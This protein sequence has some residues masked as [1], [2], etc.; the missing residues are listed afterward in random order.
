MIIVKLESAAVWVGKGSTLFLTVYN[1]GPEDLY[2]TDEEYEP[3]A[4]GPYIIISSLRLTPGVG[5]GEEALAYEYRDIE[6][7]VAEQENLL[8]EADERNRFQPWVCVSGEDYVS[9]RASEGAARL[10]KGKRLRIQ[11][12]MD[13][14]NIAEGMGLLSYSFRNW[15]KYDADKKKLSEQKAIEQQ[16]WITKASM[17]SIWFRPEKESYPYGRNTDVGWKISGAGA[18]GYRVSIDGQDM[19]EKQEGT[20]SL[21]LKEQP[22]VLEVRSN[23]TN[24]SLRE[25]FWPAWLELK[26]MPQPEKAAPNEEEKVT[27]WWNITE[28]QTCWFYGAERE[29][30]DHTEVWSVKEQTAEFSLSYYDENNFKKTYPASKPL[31]YTKPCIREF[32]PASGNSINSGGEKEMSGFIPFGEAA[33]MDA[34]VNGIYGGDDPWGP[35]PRPVVYVQMYI[36]G[37]C[38]DDNCYLSINKGGIITLTKDMLEQGAAVS[39][40]KAE[41]YIAELWDDYGCKVKAVYE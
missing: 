8:E 3:S 6:F 11:I 25:K 39:A 7:Q 23:L 40:E 32:H 10:P 9:V 21:F 24:L 35:Q 13:G 16:L 12:D 15:E 26:K 37:T 28:A 31:S 19:G 2:C 14:M 1:S 27:L 4:P 33:G 30:R 22:H 41:R 17:P 20:C 34:A 18:E 29:A 36:Q 5:D 38:M